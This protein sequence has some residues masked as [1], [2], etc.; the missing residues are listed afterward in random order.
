MAIKKITSDM[1]LFTGDTDDSQ[2][3]TLLTLDDYDWMAYELATKFKT[4]EMGV[5]EVT[6]SY[7][8]L[9]I[10][11]MDIRQTIDGS[12]NKYT[13]EYPTDIFK[14]HIVQFL[15]NHIKSWDSEFVF[16]GEDDVLSFYNDVIERGTLVK[17]ET[18]NRY[19]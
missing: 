13:Y 3:N 7:L 19:F 4:K 5:L 17:E 15:T 1:L 2:T 14:E 8:G 9:E 16:Y 6:F 11:T 10:S 18:R 12:I